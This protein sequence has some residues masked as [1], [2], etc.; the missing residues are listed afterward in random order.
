MWLRL[1]HPQMAE[2]SCD[3]CQRFV[4]DVKTGE[5]KRN[6]AT[7]LPV[8]RPAGSQT[9]CDACP[10]CQ[11]SARG[12][13]SPAE[14]RQAELSPKNQ[15][16]VDLYYQIQAAPGSV[17]LTDRVAAKMGLIGQLF[18]ER[19]QLHQRKMTAALEALLT[20]IHR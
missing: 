4:C 7:K 12:R 17:E 15:V 6:A 5:I 16:L 9:P 14:G 20:R 2:L 3:D 1:H 8:K 10:K 11:W 13:E 18:D 19:Q